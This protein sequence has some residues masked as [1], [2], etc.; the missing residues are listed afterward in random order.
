MRSL[1]FIWSGWV[2]FWASVTLMSLVVGGSVGSASARL[3]EAAGDVGYRDFSYSGTSSPTGEKP[4]SKLWYNDGIWWGSLFNTATSDFH[5]YRFNWSAQTW[6]DTGTLLDE[7][8]KSSADCLWDGTHLYIASAVSLSSSADISIS[9]MRYSYNASTQT[10]TQDPGFPVVVA[11]AAVEAVVLDKDT[12]GTLWITYTDDNGVGGRQVYVAHS[13][14]NDQTWGTPYI[15]PAPGATNLTADDISAL[16]AFDSQI[17][18]MWSNQN[19]ETMYFAAHAD[20]GPDDIWSLNPALQGPKYADDHINL[21]SL[22]ADPSGRVFAAVK[23]SLN[24]VNP[25]DPGE[26]LILLLILDQNGSWQ[27][28]TFGRV[29]DEHTRPMVLIDA[30][31]RQLYMFASIP[32]GGQTSGWIAY[33]Q[34]SLD[35]ISFVSGPGTPFIQSSLYTHINNASSTKQTLNNASNLLVIAGDDDANY[36]FHNVITL[37]TPSLTP[38]PTST[39][40]PTNMPTDTPTPTVTPTDTSTPTITPLVTDTP[41]ATPIPSD[42][43]TPTLTPTA[44]ATATPT[45]TSTPTDTPT[46]GP[47]PTHTATATPTSTPT[48]TPGPSPTPTNTSTPTDT[49]TPTATATDTS[50]PTDTPPVTNPPTGTPMPTDTPTPTP[51][52]TPTPTPTPTHTATATPTHTPTRTATATPTH[53]PT[54]TA[55]V[56]PTPTTTATPTATATPTGTSTSTPTPTPTATATPTDT[57]TPTLTPTHTATAI[58]TDTSTPTNTPTP[59]LT[60]TRTA[61]ATPT[62][63]PTQA[64]KPNFFLYLPAI[65]R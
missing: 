15:L 40:T 44:T 29:M 13:T 64:S 7:R 12:T 25:P 51:T 57:P 28:R 9:V 48:D 33:K 45:G 16:V 60:P 38:T 22:Q 37:S 8:S 39:Q 54:H 23:T 47:T 2:G 3:V 46:P 5:I 61:T 41:T 19:D 50:T 30:E 58:P 35:N 65:R 34:T 49:P 24:D 11:N 59:T 55:T 62:P 1:R 42:T 6:T 27:R 63:T 26:P 10:Y 4:Q 14:T 53:T 36:Y 20:G 31:N 43:P 18:V 21:K 52:D 32:S 17:G 56:T